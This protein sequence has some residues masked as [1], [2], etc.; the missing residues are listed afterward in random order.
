MSRDTF[1]PHMAMQRTQTHPKNFQPW[2]PGAVGTGD[3]YACRKTATLHTI[4]KECR[5]LS[6]DL[7][8]FRVLLPAKQSAY[9]TNNL[10]PRSLLG[11]DAGLLTHS[12]KDN[13]V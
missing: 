9:P 7:S 11:V 4:C 6:R 12:S 8:A 2:S 1:L 5:S 3:C 13:D 10:R